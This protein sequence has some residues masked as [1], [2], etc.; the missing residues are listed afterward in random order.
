MGKYSIPGA[1]I[2]V[3]PPAGDNAELDVAPA[4]IG[5]P[6]GVAFVC[7][8]V[9][10]ASEVWVVGT[11]DTTTAPT[12]LCDGD[13][14]DPG[15]EPGHKLNG[16]DGEKFSGCIEDVP[17]SDELNG[18]ES[19]RLWWRVRDDQGNW[20]QCSSRKCKTKTVEEVDCEQKC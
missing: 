3:K 10:N 14:P 2:W 18:I 12:D 5:D 19:I 17:C 6:E 1:A 9:S 8:R 13:E 16:P 4:D 15:L 11:D 7:L 20:G